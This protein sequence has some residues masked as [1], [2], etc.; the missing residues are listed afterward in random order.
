MNTLKPDPRHHLVTL[1]I[2][3]PKGRRRIRRVLGLRAGSA[4][5]I[6]ERDD[7]RKAQELATRRER[8]T[9]RKGKS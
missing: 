8:P 9:P 1:T 3:T 2:W 5:P 4:A 7:E 6:P